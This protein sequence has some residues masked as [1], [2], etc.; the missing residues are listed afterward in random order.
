MKKST[1]WTLLLL[2][3]PGVLGAT[4]PKCCEDAEGNALSDCTC[5]HDNAV[6]S[7]I[8]LTQGS[9]KHFHWALQDMRR[10]DVPDAERP[11]INFRVF[12]CSGSAHLFVNQLTMM[13]D[14]FP[15]IAN[16]DFN[17]TVEYAENAL[18]IP[19]YVASFS[20]SVYAAETTKFSIS[21][22]IDGKPNHRCS[23][24]YFY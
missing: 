24:A 13:P 10:V 20:V 1:C 21:A 23:P 19:I 5:L 22:M 15:T 12:S 14:P 4:L 16:H 17:S 2:G 8:E 6:L 11:E 7:D 9:Y 18:R 3:L